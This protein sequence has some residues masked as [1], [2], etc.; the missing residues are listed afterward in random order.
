ML[1]TLKG[2]PRNLKDSEG[3]GGLLR[4]V[5]ID[6]R[7]KL[8]S[9]VVRFNLGTPETEHPSALMVSVGELSGMGIQ[10]I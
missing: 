9:A 5:Y 8:Q 4:E 1:H 3:G 10:C 7:L 2:C 6:R